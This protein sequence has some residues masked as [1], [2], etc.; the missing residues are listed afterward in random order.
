MSSQQQFSFI[1]FLV[2]WF[3][4]TVLWF[5]LFILFG[6]RTRN[7]MRVKKEAERRGESPDMVAL[8]MQDAMRGKKMKEK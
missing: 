6:L 5:G 1:F 8:D 4:M 7:A 3:V 2:S